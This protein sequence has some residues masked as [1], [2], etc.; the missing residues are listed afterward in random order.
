M[1]MVIK[2]IY[3]IF[4]RELY[5]MWR[6][7]IYGFCVLLFPIV[8]AIF[9]TTLMGEGEPVNMPVGVV[10]QDNTATSRAMIRRL[11]AFQTTHVVAHYPNMNE[12]RNAIQ[13]NE[14][15]AFLLIP[16]GTTD[17]LLSSRQPKISFYY[18]SVT[19]VA[20]SLLYRDLKTIASLGSA[21]VGMAKLAALGKTEKEI[22]TF[23]QPI[24]I[25][26]HMVG[27]PWANYNIY[28][29]TVMA[30]GVL[31][32]FMFLLVPYS[33]GSELKF[34]RSR[35]WMNMAGN[36]IHIAIAG[37]ILPQSVIF[38]CVLLCY[39]F[40]I[41]Y[42]LG[43]PHPGGIIPIVLVGILTVLACQCFG[44]F[45][46]G[47]M[48]SLRMSMSICSL[49]SVISF[50]AC[51]AT[52]PLFAMDGMIQSMAQLFPLRHYYMI[53][54][55]CIFNGYPLLYAWFNVLALVIFLFLPMFSISHI[56]TAMLKYVYIP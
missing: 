3:H 35:Q 52:Y 51:G 12:A 10:D 1:D 33:I 20:G 55:M 56:K 40:Y 29:S 19:L 44:I 7:P 26:L 24:N 31:M 53:Y 37:K 25:D 48:P 36:N 11:D 6:N 49:W 15:Y 28:L 50:S 14:I 38:I 17:G 54:Q 27:N 23:L 8:V 9:F 42:G 34:H 39:E 46:F 4:I 18:S 21:N 47:L 32:I 45:V 5:I 13:R 43:F 2:R 22:R 30:P 41:F 16:K